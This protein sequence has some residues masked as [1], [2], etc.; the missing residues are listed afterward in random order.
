MA[1][2]AQPYNNVP[3]ENICCCGP[4]SGISVTQPTSQILPDGSIVNNPAFSGTFSSSFWTYKIILDCADDT[5]LVKKFAIPICFAI[6][7]IDMTISEKIDGSL[8]FTPVSFTLTTSDPVFGTAPSGFQWLIVEVAGRYGKG[9]SV[10]YRLA[11]NSDFPTAAQPI[12]VLANS[13]LIVFDCDPDDCFVVPKCA[14]QGQLRVA[15]QCGFEI[16]NNKATLLYELDVDN[17]GTASLNNVLFSDTVLIPTQLTFGTI[18]VT[19][20]TLS[21]DTST[22][23]KIKISGNLGTIKPTEY[24]IITYT[25][26]ITAISSPGPYI[27]SNSA[28]AIATGT[29]STATCSM[30]LE[31]VQLTAAKCCLVTAGNKGTFSLIISSVGASPGTTVNITDQLTVPNGVTVQFNDFGGCTATFAGSGSPVPINTNIAGPVTIN[32]QCNSVAVPAGSHAH[33]D[34]LFTIVSTSVFGTATLTNIIQQVILTNPSQQVFLGISPIPAE[35]D[36]TVTSSV[37]CQNPCS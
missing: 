10:A 30:T 6:K 22:P 29:Q 17:F 11:I 4:K 36:I 32:L 15:K 33:K 28:T 18:T 8:D 37:Q 5:K 13:S 27:I 24:V 2:P 1:T 3:Y 21:V 35:A 7:S 12:R 16:V 34:I 20:A 26:P 31:A 14:P 9:V 19:P 25:I 23:G